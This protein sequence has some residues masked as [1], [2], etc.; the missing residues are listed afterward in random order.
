MTVKQ[1][2]PGQITQRELLKQT[3]V[4]GSVVRLVGT[5]KNSLCVLTSDMMIMV[6]VITSLSLLSPRADTSVQDADS[7]NAV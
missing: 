5:S 4:V 1:K 2:D 7:L 6:F 3:Q